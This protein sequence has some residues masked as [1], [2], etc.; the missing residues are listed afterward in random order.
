MLLALMLSRI[1]NIWVIK[2]RAKPPPPAPSTPGLTDVLTEYLVDLG[3]GRSVCLR[4][5]A[6]DLQAITT[7]AWLAAPTHAEGYLEAAAKLVVYLVASLSGNMSQA[8]ALVFMALLLLT[9]G[10][11]G[12]SNAHAKSFHMHGRLVAPTL[13]RLPSQDSFPADDRRGGPGSGGS[14]GLRWPP[15]LHRRQSTDL[16]ALTDFAEEGQIGASIKSR[17]P[18]DEHMDFR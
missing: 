1:L 8:G 2:Q 16:T 4:G 7:S 9:A 14:L 12:L 13:E 11:L 18:F 10:L 17:Y 3:Q 6:A 5:L 15:V